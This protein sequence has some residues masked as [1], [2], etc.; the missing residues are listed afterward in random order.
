MSECYRS[1]LPL[2]L[3]LFSLLLVKGIPFLLVALEGIRS[4]MYSA[5]D[6]TLK[7]TI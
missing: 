5:Q 6:M 1:C 4:V 7:I 2:L 3:R